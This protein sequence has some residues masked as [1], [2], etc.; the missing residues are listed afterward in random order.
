MEID[1]K[2][3]E[4]FDDLKLEALICLEE[5]HKLVYDLL[6]HNPSKAL[7]YSS[8]LVELINKLEK[9]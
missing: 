4:K 9:L 3:N 5:M 6:K 8:A 1:V 2:I 7:D